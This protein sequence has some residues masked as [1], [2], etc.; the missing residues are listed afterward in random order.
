MG[1]SIRTADFGLRQKS[2]VTNSGESPEF[3]DH[4]IFKLR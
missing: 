1:E 2:E 3:R 4:V